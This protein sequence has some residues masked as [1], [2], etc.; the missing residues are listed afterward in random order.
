[1][2][3]EVNIFDDGEISTF[4]LTAKKMALRMLRPATFS[5]EAGVSNCVNISFVS[6]EESNSDAEP[7]K[8]Y[9]ASTIDNPSTWIDATDD[10]LPGQDIEGQYVYHV[11]SAARQE[12]TLAVGQRTQ[13]VAKQM[14]G[15]GQ[16]VR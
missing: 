3:Q 11:P 5:I 16:S 12:T 7:C 2:G 1:M 4:T 13:R 10:V 14:Q 6:P 9:S 8:P 15:K